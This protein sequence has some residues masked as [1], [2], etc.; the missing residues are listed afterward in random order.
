MASLDA[1]SALPA[2]YLGWTIDRQDASRIPA[3]FKRAA[4]ELE[5]AKN[6]TRAANG[7]RARPSMQV[8]LPALIPHFYEVDDGVETLENRQAAR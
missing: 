4:S 7:L 8:S 5:P 6:R 1:V 2:Y 3:A